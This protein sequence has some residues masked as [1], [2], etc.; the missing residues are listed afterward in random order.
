VKRNWT[1]DELLVCFNFYCRT[2][3][4]KLHRNNSDIIQLANIFRRT[5]NAVAMKLV[6]FASFD[7][8]HK[9]RGIK[10]LANASHQDEMVWEEF[11][12]NPNGLAEESEEASLRLRAIPSQVPEEQDEFEIPGGPTEG[13]A[14][15]SMRLV[16]R[17]FR[18]S[19]LAS[20]R[21]TCAFCG[22]NIPEL[23][24][25]SHIIPWNVDVTLRADPRNGL[26]LCCLHDR[27]FDRGLMAV[28]DDYRLVLS[29]RLKSRTDDA[30]HRVVFLDLQGDLIKLPDRFL[31]HQNSLKYHFTSIF[32]DAKVSKS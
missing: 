30:I 8:A 1:R 24:N 10:G 14:F 28:N 23:L 5:P 7:P 32:L 9:K 6:N 4:G 2:P 11:N 15:R 31:P 13:Q 22:L 18:K 21:F 16:Q 25:A 17:F 3:F 19:V 26:C 12:T 27:A 29:S 20:Y